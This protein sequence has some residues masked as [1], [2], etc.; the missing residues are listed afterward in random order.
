MN[1]IRQSAGSGVILLA[2]VVLILC[3][4]GIIGVW[5]TKSHMDVLGDKVFE[6]AE[7]SL[8][9]MD[10][11]LDRIEGAFKN[12]HRRVGLLSKRVNR[13]P[14][15]ETEAKAEATSLLKTLDEEVFEPL[16]SAQTWL[17]STHAVAVGVGKISEA[18]ASSKYAATHEDAV[19]V[20]MAGQLQDVSEAV[21][22]ILTTLKEVRQ[23]LIDIRDDVLSARRIALMIVARLAQVEKRMANLC[24]RI[25]TFHTRVG[26]MKGEIAAVR[27]NFQWWTMLGAVLVTLLLVWFAASQIGMVLHGWSLAKRQPQ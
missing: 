26:E 23:G 16:K 10:E 3:L 15:K 4:A 12:S 20:V 19:G 8:A 25:E 11:K 2:S 21:V 6:A 18:V 24:G 14:Q 1:V 7:E 5:S 27:D 13:L 17:D 22:E 9:F